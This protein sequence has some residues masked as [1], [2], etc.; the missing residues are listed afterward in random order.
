MPPSDRA[1]D[2]AAAATMVPAAPVLRDVMR[3]H[4]EE[5]ASLQ[6]QRRSLLFDPEATVT[7][8]ARVEARLVAHWDGLCEGRPDSVVVAAALLDDAFD[9]WDTA[10]AARAWLELGTPELPLVQERLEAADAEHLGGWAEALR[11]APAAVSRRLLPL[12]DQLAA[13]A[14]ALA[15]LVAAWGWHGELPAAIA[16]RAL[17]S[18]SAAVR[19]A[20]ARALGWASSE[21]VDPPACLR[22][23]EADDD[24]LVRRAAFW[25][26]Y[27]RDPAAGVAACRRL[28]GGAD[29]EP[30]SVRVLAWLAEPPP[31]EPAATE[32][33]AA[34]PLAAL[35]RRSL[36]GDRPELASLRR[37]VPDGFFV[38]D[39]SDEMVPGV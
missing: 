30:F 17:G 23:L 19:R 7:A 9:P 14:D 18:G 13:D 35:W 38:D 21:G 24:P 12:A 15:P 8:L 29:P 16:T 11:R 31:S 33:D 36:R 3:E 25:S 1:R 6:V 4:L 27:L 26:L 39:D 32:P 2:A 28:A 5:M 34:P 22:Q 37:E 10:S 20:L